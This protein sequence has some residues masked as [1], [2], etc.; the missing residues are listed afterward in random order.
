MSARMVLVIGGARSG[1]SAFAH[2][3][4]AGAGGEVC[5]IATAEAKDAEMR[6][7]IRRHRLSRPKEWETLE[8]Q[9]GIRLER[10]PADDRVVIFDCLTVYLSNLMAAHGLDRLGEGEGLV[11][12]NKVER[13][14]ERVV[15]E[16]LSMLDEL[17]HRCRELIVVS[18]EVG[19]GL[20]PPFR[21]GRLFRDLAGRINQ[22]LAEEADEVYLVAA[23]LPLCLK[24]GS[25]NG[26]AGRQG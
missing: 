16:A 18:N 23:G 20:V 8:L 6:E 12:E 10:F 26:N 7:R 5:F 14:A 1:K 4:A 2:S 17:R 19:M 13:E 9:G 24:G 11:P 15:E 3:L 22:K 21:L 25:G